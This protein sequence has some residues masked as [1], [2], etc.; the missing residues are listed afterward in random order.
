MIAHIDPERLPDV[1][2]RLLFAQ[3]ITQ[4]FIG[5]ATLAQQPG[6]LAAPDARPSD[7]V[8]LLDDMTEIAL[9]TAW[10]IVDDRRQSR[11]ERYLHEWRHLAPRT[12]GYTLREMGLPTGP[13]YRIILDRLR[14]ACL[15]G[16]ITDDASEQALL[17]QLIEETA[18][19][20]DD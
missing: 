10:I 14:D 15:N 2:R 13:R 9:L 5:A 4:S 16:E 7:I 3:N 17:H 1:C 20:D 6:V 11:I 8:R 12:N 18:S 19:L